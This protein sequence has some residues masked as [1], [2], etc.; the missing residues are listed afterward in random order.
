M[1]KINRQQL[2]DEVAKLCIE[3]NRELPDHQIELLK[4]AR[5]NEETPLHKELLGQVL[6]NAELSKKRTSNLSGLWNGR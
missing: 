4:K 1:R 6:E 3:A 5:E 2:T